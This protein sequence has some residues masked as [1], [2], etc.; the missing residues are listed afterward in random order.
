M[1]SV[2]LCLSV[3][4]CEDESAAGLLEGDVPDAPVHAGRALHVLV[5]VQHHAILNARMS[6]SGL[7]PSAAAP[8]RTASKVFFCAH[9]RLSRWTHMTG[10]RRSRS[11]SLEG[12]ERH[13][14][15]AGSFDIAHE[16]A[17]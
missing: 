11:A 10:M 14:L 17:F 8:A 16:G 4:V 5:G 7:T 15:I 12:E 2:K 3:D 6:I 13:E 1:V 9:L